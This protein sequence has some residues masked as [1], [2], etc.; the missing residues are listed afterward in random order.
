MKK[1]DKHPLLKQNGK[2]AIRHVYK[3]HPDPQ[4]LKNYSKFDH[5]S[6]SGNDLILTQGKYNSL[7]SDATDS[8]RDWK[9]KNV[10][11]TDCDPGKLSRLI[12]DHKMIEIEIVK[13][14]YGK[15]LIID[16][17]TEKYVFRCEDIEQEIRGYN[18]KEIVDMLI[19]RDEY[20][21]ET[22]MENVQFCEFVVRISRFVNR[23]YV[24]YKNLAELH[25]DKDI[26]LATKA[27][28]YIEILTRV[29]EK[30]DDLKTSLPQHAYLHHEKVH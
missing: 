22:E 18:R 30:L 3:R 4:A 23:E 29:K 21:N 7:E 20:L 25:Q 28:H 24:D 10:N 12:N 8:L 6:I 26:S 9:L 16:S 11:I 17:P 1:L 14:R 2:F 27:M 13:T 19:K 15:K 5:Y